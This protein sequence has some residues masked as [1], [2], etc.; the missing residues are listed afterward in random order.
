MLIPLDHVEVKETGSKYPRL[1]KGVDTKSL[2]RYAAVRSDLDFSQDVLAISSSAV[3][4]PGFKCRSTWTLDGSEAKIKDGL[5]DDII[6]SA[7][8]ASGQVFSPIVVD[9]AKVWS[10]LE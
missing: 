4:D 3:A 1:S 9:A 8:F 7:A 5:R 10:S 6:A 2:G